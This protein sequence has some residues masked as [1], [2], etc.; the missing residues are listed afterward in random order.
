[1]IYDTNN[2]RK[3]DELMVPKLPPPQSI[4]KEWENQDYHKIELGKWN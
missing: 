3:S 1:M 2:D 4:G